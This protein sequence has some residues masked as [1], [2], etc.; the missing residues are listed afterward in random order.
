M[1]HLHS[2]PDS[3]EAAEAYV[4]PELIVQGSI[5]DLTL[6][7]TGTLPDVGEAGSHLP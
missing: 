6:G 3:A 2:V 7:N 4:K 5:Q 1:D